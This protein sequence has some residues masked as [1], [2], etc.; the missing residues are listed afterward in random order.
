M[1]AVVRSRP[2][3]SVRTA[4]SHGQH[5]HHED[6][7]LYPPESEYPT[8]IVDLPSLIHWYAAFINPFW[9]K[10]LLFTVLTG[11]AVKYAPEPNED[12]YLTRWIAMYKA[13][14]GLWLELNA[15]HTA[16]ESEVSEQKLLVADAKPSPIHRF[17]YPQS[18]VI[19]FPN[20]FLI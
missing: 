12:V 15:K 4:S 2:I 19:S 8:A 20:F 10:V 16:Q 5:E 1:F 17:R 6:A 9:G 7:T 14:R 18:V 11:V 3:V 13:P